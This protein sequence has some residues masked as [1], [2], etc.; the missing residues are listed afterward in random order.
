MLFNYV[1]VYLLLQVES[2]R[3]EKK[4]SMETETTALARQREATYFGEKERA[5]IDLKFSSWFSVVFLSRLLARFG[6][7]PHPKK[8]GS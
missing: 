5:D 1:K 8:S 7:R 3:R 6:A 4:E 2:I